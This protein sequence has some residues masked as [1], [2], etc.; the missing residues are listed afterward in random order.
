MPVYESVA[1]TLPD[2]PLVGSDNPFEEIN[3][4]TQKDIDAFMAALNSCGA[5][6]PSSAQLHLSDTLPKKY[7]PPGCPKDHWWTYKCSL[8]EEPAV[9]GSDIHH[10]LPQEPATGG[11]NRW[12]GSYSTFR[13]VWKSCFK[14]ILGF[15]AWGTHAACNICVEHDNARKTA[16]T[17]A[18]KLYHAEEKRRHLHQQWRDRRIYW[19]LRSSSN[20]EEAS[21]IVIMADGADQ[22]KFRIMK[23]ARWP[24]DL[25]GEHR[26]KIKVVGALVHGHEC[27]FNFVEE[28]VPKG[29]NLTIEVI[30][31]CLDRAVADSKINRRPLATH[32]WIQMD[33]AGGEGKNQWLMRFLG[34]LVDRGCFRSCVLSFLQVGHTHEDLDGI[35]GVMSM[36]IAKMLQWDCP[37]QMLECPATLKSHAVL[38]QSM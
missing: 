14:N 3:P 28:D 9:G 7:L 37:Q 32:L 18:D 35:F 15:R 20:D 8:P 24:K 13:R 12:C 21:W 31:G 26:P 4:D 23:A 30:V 6:G 25:D 36:E 5:F 17:M 38:M 27:A 29:A 10:T 11:S 2:E 1:E 34:L 16:A 22:A 33:N 19:Q